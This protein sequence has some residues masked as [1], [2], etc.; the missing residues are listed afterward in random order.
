M[1]KNPKELWKKNNK[2][3]KHLVDY[4]MKQ[5][6]K[7]KK[8]DNIGNTKKVTYVILQKCNYVV[9]ENITFYPKVTN[10]KAPKG[11]GYI[12]RS[13]GY[14]YREQTGGY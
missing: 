7:E 9:L 3:T 12:S 2:R 8:T 11:N 4:L 13:K 10:L 6:K 5:C 14:R 1:T